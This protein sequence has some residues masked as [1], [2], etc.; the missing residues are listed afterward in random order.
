MKTHI[1]CKE[2]KNSTPRHKTKRTTTEVSPWNDQKYKNTGGLYYWH[3]VKHILMRPRILKS[4]NRTRSSYGHDLYKLCR[5]PLPDASCQVSKSKAFMLWGRIILK[6][7]AIYSHGGHLGHVNMTIYTHF[8]PRP[9]PNNAPHKVWLCLAKRF[10]RRRCLN[11]SVIYT[12]GIK[13]SIFHF[14]QQI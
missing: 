11:I 4:Q 6:V 13:L 12:I 3:K 14:H 8:H 10:Q 9:L 5:A 2:H 7:F 1:R